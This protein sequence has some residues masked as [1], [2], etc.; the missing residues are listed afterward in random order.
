MYTLWKAAGWVAFHVFPKYAWYRWRLYSKQITCRQDTTMLNKEWRGQ[1]KNV[2]E[3]GRHIHYLLSFAF[4]FINTRLPWYTDHLSWASYQMWKGFWK[5]TSMKYRPAYL[6]VQTHYRILN[7]LY[8]AMWMAQW[9]MV[10]RKHWQASA[11]RLDFGD[12]WQAPASE[13]QPLPW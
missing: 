3:I 7:L 13:R 6:W 4:R 12:V 9:W 8:S 2:S 11:E 5:C 1:I 10:I